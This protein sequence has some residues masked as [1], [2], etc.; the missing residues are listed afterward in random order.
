MARDS[1]R[2]THHKVGF[3]RILRNSFFTG[4]VVVAPVGVTAWLVYAFVTFVDAQV[5][6]LI[7]PAYNPETYLP[8]AIPGLGLV[9]AIGFLTVLGALAAN[10]FGRAI[11]DIGERIVDRVPLVRNIYGA[12][13][14]LV[15]TII[16]SRETAFSEVALVEY[17]RKGAHALCFITADAQGEVSNS[18]GEG[19]VGV[20][21]PTTP[22]P[23][24]GFLLYVRRDELVVLD[25]SV[26]EG[27]KLIISAGLVTPEQEAARVG[28]RRVRTGA[29][30]PSKP[31]A[32]A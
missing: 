20:F 1:S 29:G 26:E 16:A 30:A 12:L 19:Y 2:D 11:L 13:K 22:N 7:P 18:L 23:T 27:A 24:S 4:V 6:P 32:V 25:M 17:P 21:I 5:K 9:F 28:E 3:L 15:G 10:F 8:F 14:Q 31:L